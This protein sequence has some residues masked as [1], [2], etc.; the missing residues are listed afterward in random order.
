MNMLNNNTS[1]E[2]PRIVIIGAGFGGMYAYKKLQSKLGS[3]VSYT[4]I[5]NTDHFLFTPLLHEVATGLLEG[6]HIVEPVRK[7]IDQKNTTF[8]I[9]TL[10]SVDTTKEV[11]LT[12]ESEIP[13]DFLVI[14]TGALPQYWGIPG[15]EEYTIPLKSLE[16]AFRIRD[17]VIESFKKALY[18]GTPEERKSYLSFIVIGGGATGVELIAEVADMCFNT[19]LTYYKSDIK[20]EEIIVALV[21]ATDELVPTFEPNV[22]TIARSVLEK[23]GILI[24]TSTFV[25]SIDDEGITLKDGT[26]M[27]SKNVFFSAGVKAQP[28]LFTTMTPA[29]T[30]SGRLVVDETLRLPGKENIFA[31]GDVATTMDQEGH[32]LLMLAQIA[33]TEGEYVGHTISNILKNRPI[34]QYKSRIKGELLSLGE[35]K[36]TGDIFGMTVNGP[37]AWL[38]WR[39]IYLFKFISPIKR[40]RIAFDWLFGDIIK[41]SK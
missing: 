6:H 12:K 7:L 36:A 3:R 34:K 17:R 16:D 21:S 11:V 22:R 27:V 39:T 35:W 28:P 13:Y 29:L 41:I 40:V 15:A 2:K 30:H 26:T 33:Q 1:G 37:F 31:I 8:V 5:N 32:E 20:K 10:I 24:Y 19:F 23:K 4:I 38:L 14:A 9:D 18:A 25:I